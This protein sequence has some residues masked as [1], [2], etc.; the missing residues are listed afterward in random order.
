MV[1]P[2]IGKDYATLPD[3]LLNLLN[4]VPQ[5]NFPK[6]IPTPLGLLIIIVINLKGILRKRFPFTEKER[7]VHPFVLFI[8]A[9]KPHIRVYD[10][11]IFFLA[12]QK[13]LP[14]FWWRLFL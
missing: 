8:P 4:T 3:Q 1:G 5:L 14:L 6:E 2:H 13:R 9:H 12:I 11:S 7:I 10:T